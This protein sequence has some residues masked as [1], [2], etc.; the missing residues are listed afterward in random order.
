LSIIIILLLLLI[1]IIIAE[2]G[3]GIL[4]GGLPVRVATR[5]DVPKV[6]WRR[7]LL[8]RLQQLLR[9]FSVLQHLKSLKS[10]KT[11]GPFWT[12]NG[13]L[14]APKAPQVKTVAPPKDP[15]VKTMLRKRHAPKAP[16][17]KT[18]APPQDP[19]VPK[20]KTSVRKRQAPKAPK[21]KTLARNCGRRHLHLQSANKREQKRKPEL[22][23]STTLPQPLRGHRFLPW[24][25][26][27][28]CQIPQQT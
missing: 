16:K 8:R 1:I 20:V 9:R 28:P 5:G 15:K 23:R 7:R 21:M 24:E 14:T 12:A 27:L 3:H 26:S 11:N 22:L 17:I 18:A 10:C 6:Q 19:K 25:H 13:L 4:N 2:F